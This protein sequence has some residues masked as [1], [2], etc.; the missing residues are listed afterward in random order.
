[1][2]T[3]WADRDFSH[4]AHKHTPLTARWDTWN[5]GRQALGQGSGC[6]SQPGLSGRP[7]PAVSSPGWEGHRNAGRQKPAGS[8]ANALPAG[9]WRGLLM[10]NIAWT[11]RVGERVK[12]KET[13]QTRGPSRNN[14]FYFIENVARP[15]LNHIYSTIHIVTYSKKVIRGTSTNLSVVFWRQRSK[16]LKNAASS[17]WSLWLTWSFSSSLSRG[18][19]AKV[20]LSALSSKLS[21]HAVS[22]M[23]ER[24]RDLIYF[25]IHAVS[26]RLMKLVLHTVLFMYRF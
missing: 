23:I 8:E 4:V 25:P 10:P 18:F 14:I 22:Y 3:Y 24:H 15:F 13:G 11:V 6:S 26:L 21:R 20:W 17:R 2:Q 9:S 16:V 12:N 1:M 5:R 19:W 7:C